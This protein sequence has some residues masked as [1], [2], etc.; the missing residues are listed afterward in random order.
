MGDDCVWRIAKTL[1]SCVPGGEARSGEDDSGDETA[2]R[3]SQFAVK[4]GAGVGA[5]DNI[6]ATDCSLLVSGI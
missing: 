1:S 6:S 4:M 2:G 3:W 5:N